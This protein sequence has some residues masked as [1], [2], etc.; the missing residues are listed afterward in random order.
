[1]DFVC[2]CVRIPKCG[3]T[4]LAGSLKR[5][6]AGRRIFYLPHTLN[7]EGSFSVFQHLRFCRTQATHLLSHYRTANLAKACQAIEAAARNGDLI[8]GGHIDFESVRR[9]IRRPVKIIT[10]L[11]DPVERCRS[12]YEY[13]RRAHFRKSYLSRFD[14]PL[15]HQMAARYDFHGY[16][17]FL[18][19]HADAYGNLAA[20][21]IGWD[22]A[23]DLDEFFAQHVFHSGVLERSAEFARGLAGKTGTRLSFPHD[24]GGARA[25][26]KITRDERA[27]IEKLY[28]RDFEL[29]E[30]KLADLASRPGHDFRSREYAMRH[31]AEY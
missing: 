13:C 1:M 16:V 14:A 24:N 6:F 29:Y 30:W 17:D 25:R 23:A 31:G 12:E 3:S 10:L 21:F 19:D 9:N 20:R 11:R 2:V 28:P 26:G 15:K 4:S 8:S 18:L 7:L 22:G 27:G 5:A